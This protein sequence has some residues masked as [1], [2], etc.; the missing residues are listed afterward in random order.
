MNDKKSLMFAALLHDIGKFYQRTGKKHDAYYNNLDNSDY[1]L[2]GAHGKWSADFVRNCSS[3]NNPL[4]ED[5][6]LYHHQH[7]KSSNSNLCGMLRNADHDSSSE[8]EDEEDT[9]Q[10]N[11]EPLISIFSKINLHN[12]TLCD[13]YYVPLREI[14]LDDGFNK[15]KPTHNKKEVM[16][17]YDL[18]PEYKRLWNKFLEDLDKINNK[19]DFTTWLYLL[20]KYTSAIPSAVYKSIPDIS[21]YDHL[22]TTAALSLATYEYNEKCRD[23]KKSSDR[24]LIYL[25]INGD[26]SGIQKFIYRISSP[27]DAQKNMSKRLRGRSLY[28]S[29]LIDSVVEYIIHELELSSANV[30]FSA[31]GRF[32]ILADN[33]PSTKE[34]L[35]KIAKEINNYFINEFNSELYMSIVSQECTRK[36]I[37]DFG[38]IINKLNSKL[39][40]DKKHKFIDNLKE[41]FYLED[42]ISHDNTCSI[43]G[44][45]TDKDNRCNTCNKHVDLGAKV[46]NCKYLIKCHSL[47]DSI[48]FDIYIPPT[49]TGY[50]FKKGENI[51]DSIN[52]YSEEFE[53]VEVSKLNNTKDFLELSKSVPKDNVSFTFSFLGNSVP[54]NNDGILSFEQ[55]AEK[56]KG[57]NKIGIL[58]MDVD[59]L[60]QIFSE[61]FKSKTDDKISTDKISISRISTLS[62]YLDMF[63]L[64]FI[65]EFTKKHD[66]YINYSGGDDLLVIGAYDNII[67]F[68]HE[69]R[70][71]FK[72]WTCQNKSINISGGIS[73][74]GSKFPIGKA[75]HAAD[76]NLSKSKNAGKDKI[77]LFDEILSWD[78]NGTC[79][80]YNTLL[81]YGKYLEKNVEDEKLSKGF[82]Y[83]LLKIWN[84]SR[85]N[86]LFN[87]NE[88]NWEKNYAKKIKCKLY[89]PYYKYKLRLIKDK[90]VFKRLDKEGMKY[91]PWIKIPVSWVS[92]R[93][94]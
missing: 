85:P 67:Q 35:D 14:N 94:R 3:L 46:A 34:K 31:G 80:G 8:R 55:L 32:T 90:D 43:C 59:D 89:V 87:V 38:N 1:G 23:Y 5:L 76:R 66:I 33:T 44:N 60:G 61:G 82:I 73:I 18:R 21:L 51:I 58:K 81:E 28:I 93:Q 50:I 70:E 2:T 84:M 49:N 79:Y 54:Q 83:S 45:L 91:M 64:G 16:S 86:D 40:A 74:V 77:T 72:Q 53:H 24:Q 15:S 52:K 68:T 19:E 36:N 75:I 37:S 22:K 56:A 10:V 62:S 30:L 78:D 25:M 88:T 12:N 57:A 27:Q 13:E 7:T 17:G 92:L 6:V 4:I 39:A 9:K 20:K 48:D 42:K 29:L 63:F 41:V 47:R 71:K 26:L 65:N 69:F 11:K